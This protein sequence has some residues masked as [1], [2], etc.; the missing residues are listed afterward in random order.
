MS[1]SCIICCGVA[2]SAAVG[3]GDLVLGLGLGS[4]A[5]VGGVA[6]G[7]RAGEDDILAARSVHDAQQGKH[8]VHVAVVVPK[9]LHHTLAHGMAAD[10]A[11]AA[12][13]KNP[14]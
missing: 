1:D 2:L 7:S 9:R 11:S 14:H 12:G 4:G 13:N 3:V 5:H 8:S 10:E 6:H